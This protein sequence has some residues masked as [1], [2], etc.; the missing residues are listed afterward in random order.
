MDFRDSPEEA[1]SGTLEIQRNIVATR[2][3]S[4]PRD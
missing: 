4:L 1:A 2:G 3:L